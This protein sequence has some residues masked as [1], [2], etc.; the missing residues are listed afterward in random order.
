MFYVNVLN[1]MMKSPPFLLQY[2]QDMDHPIF[3]HIH[4]L[5][6]TCIHTVYTTHPLGTQWPSHF[7][8]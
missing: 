4:T 8:D 1:S 5:Y 7:L 6:A 2:A 3:E